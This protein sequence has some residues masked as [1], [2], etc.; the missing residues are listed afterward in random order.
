MRVLSLIHQTEAA[1]G[2]FAE[3]AAVAGHELAEWNVAVEPGPPFEPDAV[4]A[5]GGTMHVDQADRHPWLR[6]EGELLRRWLGE[7][8]PVLGVCLGGQLVAKALDAPVRR[9]PSAEIGWFAV[10]LTAE[11]ASDPLFAC[12]PERFDALE[13]H[14]YAFE[15]P[16]GAVPLARNGRCLQAYRAGASAW[17]LQFHAETTRETLDHWIESCENGAYDTASLRAAS[18]ARI[19]DWTSFGRELCRR[20]LAVAEATPAAATTRATSRRS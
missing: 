7:G 1:S 10:E 16:N 19:A 20:F 14:S 2:V 4:L 15:L 13:W 8:V 5:F 17:G 3:A 6:D 9:M 11:A 18:D 12:L